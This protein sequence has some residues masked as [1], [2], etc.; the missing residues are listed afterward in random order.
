MRARDVVLI[1]DE[2]KTGIAKTGDLFACE[3]EGVVPD[4]LL[5]GKSL[6]GGAAPIG[7]VI[8]KKKRW[9]RLGLSFPMSS[10]SGAGNAL[11]CAAGLASLRVVAEERLAA[12]AKQ[13]GPVVLAALEAIARDLPRTARGAS[14][15]GLLAALH[16]DTPRSANEVV[17]ACARRGVLVMVAF[18]SRARILFAPPLA[19]PG[20]L[21]DEAL[22]AIR[23]AVAEVDGRR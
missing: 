14:G 17:A 16:L 8:A 7:A 18:C 4:V 3:H 2:V 9:G 22:A 10:S 13:K 19:S 12:Q 23:D 20:A 5:A 21:L 11:A 1:V 15:R 6:G